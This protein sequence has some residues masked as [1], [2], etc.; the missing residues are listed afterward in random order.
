MAAKLTASPFFREWNLK[1]CR[2]TP[3]KKVPAPHQKLA[4][5]NLNKWYASLGGEDDGGILVLPT[6]G[7]KTFT[8]IHF[9]CAG[10]LSA[11]YKVLWLAHTH[12]L[13]EQAFYAFD[14]GVLAQ[15]REPRSSL[16]LRVVSGTPGH[17]PPRSI[18]PTDDVVIATLQTVTNAHRE[19]LSQ[20][21]DFIKSSKGKLFIVFDEA[22]HSPAPSY[23]KLLLDLRELGS[24]A[25]G[26]T[27]T[28][29]YSDE[30]KKGWLKKLF[31]QGI[32]AQAKAS[33]LIA[34]GV[35][36]RPH[37]ERATTSVAPKFDEPDYQKWLGSYRDIPEDII[38]QLARNAERNALIAKTYADNRKKYGKTIIFTDRWFQCEAIAQAL[39]KNKI[40]AGSVYSHVDA[41]V[42]GVEARRSRDRDENAKVLQRFRDNEIDVLINVR[43]LTEG[44]DLPDAQ[45]VFLTRQTTS[46]I[47]LTQMVG[48]ALRGPKFGGTADAYI[49]SFV[50]EWQ[51]AIRWAEYD[52]LAE[53]QA[54]DGVR[55][56]SKRPP[57]QLISID[58]VQRLARQM[59]GGTNVMAVPFTS[60]MPTGWF[61]VVFDVRVAGTEDI[62][63]TDQ[64]V[65]VFEDE[66][67]G[68]DKLIAALLKSVPKSFEREDVDFQAERP[69]LE[70]WRAAYLP[71]AARSASDLLLE[72]FHLARHIGQGHGAPE[73]F[74]FEVRKD[75]D[76]DRVAED[77]IRRDLGPRA[78][79]EGLLAEFARADRFWRALFPRFEHFR[80][81][82]DACQTRVLT[83]GDGLGPPPPTPRQDEVVPAAEPDDEVKE[84][85]KRRD[86]Y[87]CVACGATRVPN[88]DHIVPVYR[89]GTHDMEN[90]QTLCK[91]CNT[92][93]GT[94]T[95]RFLS[96]HS[97][98]RAPPKELESFDVPR[99]E[100]A[101]DRDHWERFLRKTINFSLCCG[102][103]ARVGIAGKGE[104]YYNW[105]VELF[106]GNRPSWL[107][108]HLNALVARIQEAREAGGKPG[109]DSFTVTAPGEETVCWR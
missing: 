35:L 79:H 98:L 75:H 61:R 9:L 22:H 26:L 1:E 20:L 29:T 11:G 108:P 47:L 66:R 97:P 19:R 101:A 99:P 103:V 53:G 30:T 78:I 74:P 109:I 15:V 8:A 69:S 2:S 5:G 94:R 105:T 3:S 82:Y 36:A 12:H 6:G 93:K 62:D 104:G 102:A 55:P 51:Q 42:G 89:G 92:R 46:Q 37:F 70:A 49:V 60:L 95:L 40:K 90:L 44:T 24:P 58:L 81:Y 107:E 50:D 4:L 84:Q 71:D 14:P 85:V 38:D 56:T 59:D 72:I 86:G 52:P 83:A 64:L 43:M 45:T 21:E 48:R 63:A 33:D 77:F 13:L 106:R 91:G 25:L 10:P 16:S 23:R 17:F 73:F 41:S 88:V 57:L 67:K 68:F 7:G 31:P 54:D 34:Q 32:L 27:A 87:A 18:R 65:M 80:N 39:A 76:L 96:H 100:N 28:P